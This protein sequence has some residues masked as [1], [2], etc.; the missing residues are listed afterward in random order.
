M[1]IELPV[2]RLGLAGFSAEQKAELDAMLRHTSP[3]GHMWQV[4]KFADAE[5][6]WV[7]GSR[8]QMLSDGNVR[9]A[10]GTPTERSLQLDLAQVD[11]PIV[12][13]FVQADA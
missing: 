9:V 10:P 1:S 11:R 4:G 12:A 8:L 7:N 5:A 13:H 3:G 6:W 2:L